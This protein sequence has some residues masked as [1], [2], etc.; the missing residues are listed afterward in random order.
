MFVHGLDQLVL[1]KNAKKSLLKPHV[2][3]KIAACGQPQTQ[4]VNQMLAT[5]TLIKQHVMLNQSACGQV[6]NAIQMSAQFILTPL[7]A[8]PMPNAYGM[9]QIV[10]LTHAQPIQ[11]IQLARLKV[12]AIGLDQLVQ[13]TVA[14]RILIQLLVLLN[15]L[16]CGLDLNA[17]PTPVLLMLTTQHVLLTQPVNGMAP[18]VRFSALRENLQLIVV[19]TQS[20]CGPIMLVPLTLVKHMLT[21]LLVELKLAAFGPHHQHHV[22]LTHAH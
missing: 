9:I 13:Q 7:H 8:V 6:L 18:N 12:S 19:L 11:Q 4:N 22:P 1:Q 10:C 21:T 14:T 16:V 17:T 5:R 2:K 20:V 3:E 15:Q